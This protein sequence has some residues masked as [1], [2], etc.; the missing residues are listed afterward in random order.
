MA[1]VLVI[2]DERMMCELLK[3]VLARHGHEIIMAFNGRD[4]IAL[5]KQHRPRITLL[6]LV[7]PDINGIQ[8]L[9]EIR[10]IDPHAPA[11]MLT[12][13]A[14]EAMEAQARQ[15]GILD[16]L[17]KGLSVDVL[18]RALEKALQ[19]PVKP[20]QTRPTFEE[21][22]EDFSILVVDDDEQIRSLLLKF[23][24][25]RGYQVQTATNGPQALALVEQEPP[26]LI[27]LDMYLPGMNGIE[28][29]RKLQA[30]PTKSDVLVLS[31][32]Q[33]DKL[34]QEAM[35][36]GA[37]DVMGKPPTLDAIELAIQ[38]RQVISAA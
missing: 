2:D 4:G 27:I 12:G 26:N 24:S 15:M 30:R 10:A 21:T 18:V 32:S 11:L 33:D 14:T 1:T 23:L 20:S 16:F 5:F 36:L 7:L 9:Q 35:E 13:Q 17:R 6:D 22:S 31:S 28:V 37:F 34:L 19:P 25:R 38:L 8:V 29:L 3:A